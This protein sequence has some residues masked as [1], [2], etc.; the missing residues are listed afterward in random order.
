MASRNIG[1]N[2]EDMGIE[3]AVPP[4]YWT[5][6]TAG[7]TAETSSEA[8]SDAADDDFA[9]DT[10]PR[11]SSLKK[12]TLLALSIAAVTAGGAVFAVN[13]TSNTTK[14]VDYSKVHKVDDF[15]DDCEETRR[16]LVVPGSENF[17]AAKDSSS[18][19]GQMRALKGSSKKRKRVS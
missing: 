10:A 8:T 15:L 16:V 7:F 11:R 4:S 3:V 9:A 12:V 14:T 17:H 13:G 2:D 18:N 6:W 5:K 1:D 19:E